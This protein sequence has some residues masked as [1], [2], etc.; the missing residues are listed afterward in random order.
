MTS[1]RVSTL[2]PA[3]IRSATVRP[4]LAPSRR[5]DG[6]DRGGLGMVEPQAPGPAVTGDAGGDVDEQAFLLVWSD[7]HTWT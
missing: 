1:S 4:S 2:R 3:S 5:K 6:D 7:Q